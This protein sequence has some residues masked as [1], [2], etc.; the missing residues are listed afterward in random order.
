[1]FACS[2]SVSF[3]TAYAAPP[4]D[5]FSNAQVLPTGE[6]LAIGNLTEA[7]R[8]SG[9]SYHAMKWAHYSVWFK[10][11]A[12]GNGVMTM[13]TLGSDM[14]TM[15]AVYKGTSINNIQEVASNDDYPLFNYRSRVVFGTVVGQTY[16]VA[17]DW[18]I[19]TNFE[20]GNIRL[21]YVLSNVTSNDNFVNA[22]TLPGSNGQLFTATN[23]G[24]SKEFGEPDHAGN[25]G[26]KSVRFKWTAPAGNARPY[27]F[28]VR[29]NSANPG[30]TKQT[31]FA[32]YKGSSV[33]SLT[34]V[35][36]GKIGDF[37]KLVFT[38]TPGTTYYLGTRDTTLGQEQ[39]P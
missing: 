30:G 14:G 9:E 12:P 39:V 19:K 35:G 24:A 2:C 22:S 20:P 37:S 38:P 8:E 21:N 10:Y 13:D 18:D 34:E 11:T 26:G 16:Y 4:N 28:V 32:V 25:T 7:S 23:A 31:M 15:L 3:G 36:R 27:Q 5:A 6:S 17:I 1:M 33:S 29:S